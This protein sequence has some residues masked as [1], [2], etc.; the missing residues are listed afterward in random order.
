MPVSGSDNTTQ[1]NMKKNE[2]YGVNVQQISE[3]QPHVAAE[4]EEVPSQ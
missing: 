4:Y 3:Q 2:V 1:I